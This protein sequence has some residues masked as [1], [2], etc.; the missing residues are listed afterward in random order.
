MK[1][2]KNRT[3]PK[4]TLSLVHAILKKVGYKQLP[5]NYIPTQPWCPDDIDF[6]TVGEVIWKYGKG[7]F[8][9]VN[10]QV[11]SLNN[12][13]DSLLDSLEG[14]TIEEIEKFIK[15]YRDDYWIVGK[16]TDGK[17]WATVIFKKRK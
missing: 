6:E 9:T 15:K 5:K 16:N 13:G 11:D 12:M 1:T 8:E 7:T 17:V 4:L 14:Y 3:R 2:V 10:Y